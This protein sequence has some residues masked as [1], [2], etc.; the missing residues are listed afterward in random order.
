MTRLDFVLSCKDSLN[1][2]KGHCYQDLSHILTNTGICTAYNAVDNNLIYNFKKGDNYL[3]LFTELYN[4]PMI[5]E[6]KL[7][8][9]F[10]KHGGIHLIL[11]T[12]QSE[13]FGSSRGYFQVP[14]TEM[15]S[16]INTIVY[17]QY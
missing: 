14:A 4:T 7:A 10:G 15:K 16:L 11:D 12:H 8:Q 2:I 9:S 17:N 5:S 6:A 3:N 1:N 13:I